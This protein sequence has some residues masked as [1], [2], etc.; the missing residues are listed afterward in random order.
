MM[1]E[2]AKIKYNYLLLQKN[3]LKP[4][5]FSALS[6]K[7]FFFLFLLFLFS[8]NFFCINY[9]VLLLILLLFFF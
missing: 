7:V 6:K 9:F 3:I 4:R 2:K 1:A 8:F 5:R